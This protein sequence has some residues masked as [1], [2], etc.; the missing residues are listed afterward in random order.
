MSFPGDLRTKYL[1]AGGGI[2]TYTTSN[3]GDDPIW[4]KQ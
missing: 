3:P 1:A 2:G 4:T